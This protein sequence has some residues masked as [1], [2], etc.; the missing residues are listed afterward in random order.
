MT[1]TPEHVTVPAII[2]PPEAKRESQPS[3]SEA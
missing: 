3:P 1:A 2:E